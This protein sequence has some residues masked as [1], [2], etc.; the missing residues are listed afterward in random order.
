MLRQ[1]AFGQ[2]QHDAEAAQPIGK[3]RGLGVLCIG[4]GKASIDQHHLVPVGADEEAHDADDATVRMDLKQ[5]V[6]EHGKADG[7]AAKHA[8]GVHGMGFL[9][10][11]AC[12]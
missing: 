2:V 8:F 5:T 4:G 1:M 11:G 12:P 9:P 7:P 3:A 10:W 6:V